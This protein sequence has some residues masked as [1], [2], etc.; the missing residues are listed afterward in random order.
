MNNVRYNPEAMLTKKLSEFDKQQIQS[1]KE[2]MNQVK[3][4]YA[5]KLYQEYCDG[6]NRDTFDRWL[7][8]KLN[9]FK[10]NGLQNINKQI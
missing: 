1:I 2:V 9:S 5:M 10:A 8:S 4:H 6:R 7:F 3:Y